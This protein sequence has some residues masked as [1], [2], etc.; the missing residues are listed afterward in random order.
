[1]IH[2][3]QLGARISRETRRAKPTFIYWSDHSEGNAVRVHDSPADLPVVQSDR[4]ELVINAQTARMLGLTAPP[5]L[6][7]RPCALTATPRLC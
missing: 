7:R 1:M 6:L 2:W 4:L 5:L 3:K